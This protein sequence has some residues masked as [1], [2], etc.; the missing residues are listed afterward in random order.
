MFDRISFGVLKSSTGRSRNHGPAAVEA[1]RLVNMVCK[2]SAAK[3][4]IAQNLCFLHKP[5]WVKWKF[6]YRL[7]ALVG[8]DGEKILD[9]MVQLTIIFDVVRTYLEISLSATSFADTTDSRNTRV[10]S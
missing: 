9:L 2:C 8:P 4:R 6:R 1:I 7:P 3:S 10:R 5:D